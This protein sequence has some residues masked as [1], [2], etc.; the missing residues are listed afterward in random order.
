M[1]TQALDTV[2]AYVKMA[3]TPCKLFCFRQGYCVEHFCGL[4]RSG[5]IRVPRDLQHPQQV[6]VTSFCTCSFYLQR[7]GPRNA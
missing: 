7:F 5:F 4:I 3:L 6:S 1:T 2:R